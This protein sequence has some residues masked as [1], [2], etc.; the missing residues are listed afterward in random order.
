MDIAHLYQQNILIEHTQN[1]HGSLCRHMDT[2]QQN[3]SSHRQQNSKSLNTETS[4][5]LVCMLVVVITEIKTP[6]ELM[7]IRRTHQMQQ[8]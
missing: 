5:S 4:R 1:K 7:P 6:V 8:K 3:N 2:W